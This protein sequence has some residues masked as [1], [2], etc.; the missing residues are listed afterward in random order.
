M[1]M[2]SLSEIKPQF[3]C[4]QY[5]NIQ[6]VHVLAPSVNTQVLHEVTVV[7][8]KLKLFPT[9]QSATIS[10]N[11]DSIYYDNS[12]VSLNALTRLYCLYLSHSLIIQLQSRNIDQ[13]LS[14]TLHRLISHCLL[15]SLVVQCLLRVREVPGPSQ[16][17]RHSNDVIKMVPV[18]LFSTEHSKGKMLA[19]S[20]ELRQEKINVTDKIWD[21]KSFEVGGHWPLWRG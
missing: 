9:C 2:L 18:P 4:G 15:D 7:I 6:N 16:G 10:L 21:R 8:Y 13:H 19:L 11:I 14:H 1:S 20:Q 12:C 3:T 17:P 5:Q